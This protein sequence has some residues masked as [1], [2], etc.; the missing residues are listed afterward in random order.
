MTEQEQKEV[1]WM[2][3][4]AAKHDE[5]VDEEIM[6]KIAEEENE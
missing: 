1:E 5:K 4:I 3:E 2:A 6:K